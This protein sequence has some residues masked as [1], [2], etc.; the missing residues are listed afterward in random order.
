MSMN[1]PDYEQS[2]KIRKNIGYN[3]HSGRASQHPSQDA[4]PT[5]NRNQPDPVAV[6]PSHP[7]A[8]ILGKVGVPSREETEEEKKE[9]KRQQL[10]RRKVPLESWE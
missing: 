4:P 10:E 3:D 8:S 2:E 1:P 6:A 5:Y 7:Q 9:R